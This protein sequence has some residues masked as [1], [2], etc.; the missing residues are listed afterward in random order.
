M[1][2][3]VSSN[4]SHQFSLIEINRKN[5][6]VNLPAG[7]QVREIMASIPSGVV[8]NNYTKQ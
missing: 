8:I 2:F 6:R 1:Y 4:T 7:R 3:L 5:V